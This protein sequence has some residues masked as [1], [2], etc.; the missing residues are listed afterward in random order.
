MLFRSREYE[1]LR[2]H[3]KCAINTSADNLDVEVEAVKT[4]LTATDATV[5]NIQTTVNTIQANM[6]RLEETMNRF[7]AFLDNNHQYDDA[8]SMD[9]N[10]EADVGQNQ[11]RG[12]GFPG[13]GR[14]FCPLGE[15]RAQRVD[16]EEDV[17]GKPKFTIP[18]FL[19]KDVEEYINWEMRME[20]RKS[21]V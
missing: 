16:A 3:L 13:R 9:G 14:G 20:D 19:G 1:A 21:V 7:N 17:F 2:D 5:N 4:Q 15:P 8:A 10:E 18:K 6:T 11:G 12:R